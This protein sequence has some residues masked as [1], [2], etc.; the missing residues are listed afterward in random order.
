[1]VASMRPSISNSERILRLLDSKLH[2]SIELNIYGRAALALGFA[3]PHAEHYATRD[4]DAVIPMNIV[5]AFAHNDDFWNAQEAVNKELQTESL[6]ITHIF[7]DADVIIRANWIDNRV[8][9]HLS[10]RMLQ[11]YRPSTLDLILTKMMRDDLQDL[12]DVEFLISNEP[13]IAGEI[14]E[15]FAHAKI[16]DLPELLEQFEQMKPKVIQ[17]ARRFARDGTKKVD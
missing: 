5:E 14:P 11:V 1:M 4:V 9:I 10:F 3:H 15:V 8:P 12:A 7:S 16:P 6:Y 2:E 17:I 13:D